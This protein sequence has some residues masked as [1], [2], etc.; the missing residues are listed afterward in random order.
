MLLWLWPRPAAVALIQLLALELPYVAGAAIKRKKL[1]R[2]HH[3]SVETNPASIRENVGLIHGLT[4][5]VKDPV[6]Q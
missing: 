6:L 4:Q 5:R 2:F 3:G 1:G